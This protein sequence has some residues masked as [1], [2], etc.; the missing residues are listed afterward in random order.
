MNA[1][2]LVNALQAICHTSYSESKIVILDRRA[3]NEN[4][5]TKT[6]LRDIDTIKINDS[7]EVEIALDEVSD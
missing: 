7:G 4:G 6:V 2:D 3:K 1:V 5:V